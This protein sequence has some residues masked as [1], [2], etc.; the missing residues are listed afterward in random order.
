MGCGASQPKKPLT[1]K[2]QE[3]E[4]K[5]ERLKIRTAIRERIMKPLQEF[6]FAT[7]Y[8]EWKKLPEAP[9]IPDEEEVNLHTPYFPYTQPEHATDEKL[10]EQLSKFSAF[11]SPTTTDIEVIS[12]G[13]SPSQ[14][15]LPPRPPSS[16]TNGGFARTTSMRSNTS[17]ASTGSK[18]TR[19]Q[20]FS[21][22]H[23]VME[24]DLHTTGV[25]ILEHR[26][27]LARYSMDSDMSG[28][29]L[30][31]RHTMTMDDYEA[32]E[33]V[34]KGVLD[35]DSLRELEKSTLSGEGE[36]QAE[37]N[38][39]AD[40]EN[41]AYPGS[42]TSRSDLS[43]SPSAHH[44]MIRPAVVH[45]SRAPDYWDEEVY[46]DDADAE[47]LGLLVPGVGG[48]SMNQTQN[49]IDGEAPSSKPTS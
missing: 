6:R 48:G 24:R 2:E 35:D 19:G 26:Q 28:V 15:G 49:S 41:P 4:L 47:I 25:H 36:S 31:K 9:V 18:Y 14:S 32:V 37:L 43:G 40:S 16:H 7:Q 5:R 42:V 23:S 46:V 11:G 38:S 10:K 17:N 29:T 27:S 3:R 8:E 21:Q 39:M 44:Y 20:L 12:N 13:S 34:P 1:K 22:R 45:A 30:S 33:R